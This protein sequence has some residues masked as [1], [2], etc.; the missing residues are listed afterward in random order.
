MAGLT[1]RQSTARR[2]IGA[3]MSGTPRLKGTPLKAAREQQRR[4][5]I[6]ARRFDGVWTWKAPKLPEY[7]DRKVLLRCNFPTEYDLCNLPANK[8]VLR[9]ATGSA[10]ECREKLRLL[11]HTRQIKL[12][13]P[14]YCDARFFFAYGVPR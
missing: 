13:T 14:I 9:V 7:E 8:V 12:L 1:K 10:A 5:S 6:E 2:V 4:A 3:S 11:A